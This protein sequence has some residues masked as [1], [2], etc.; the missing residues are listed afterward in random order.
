MRLT[1]CSR[2][3]TAY[4]DM[5]LSWAV[6]QTETEKKERNMG[7]NQLVQFVGEILKREKRAGIR[8]E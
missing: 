6:S 7:N 1:S 8:M 4:C 2:L 5:S 3:H